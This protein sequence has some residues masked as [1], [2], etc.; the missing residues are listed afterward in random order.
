MTFIE[1]DGGRSQSKR[2][3][4]RDDCAVV[5]Y[6]IATGVSYDTAYDRYARAGR[7]SSRS[8]PHAITE[9]LLA[10][11]GWH[12][13]TFPAVKGERRMN[14]PTFLRLFSEGTFIVAT[15]KHLTAVV[16]GRWHDGY[17]PRPDRCI[18]RAWQLPDG[19]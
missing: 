8:T 5:A 7:K 19:P 16:D 4:Q 11:E 10:A 1:D 14:P 2:P 18:Y 13:M 6:A 12:C 17:R 9:D 3:K 15:A